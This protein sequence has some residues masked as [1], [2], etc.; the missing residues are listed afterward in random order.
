MSVMPA[1]SFADVQEAI[2]KET[3]TVLPDGRTTICQLTLVNG[4]TVFGESSCVCIENFNAELGNKYSRER[5]VDKVWPLLGYD[6]QNKVTA[7]KRAGQP[8]GEILTLGSPVTY[9]GTKVIHAVAMTRQAYNDL[10]G[11]KLPEGECGDDNGYL[12][13]YTDGG[14]PNVKGFAGYVSW[15]PQG[16]FEK[17]YV[18]GIRQKPE[19]YLDRLQVEFSELTAKVEK[20][21]LFISTTAFSK[22]SPVAQNDL[23]QQH[24]AMSRYAN[25]LSRRIVAA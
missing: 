15:S 7:I 18:T 4:Y 10:R 16:V 22:L 20:L 3:Y 17:A 6:L 23:E 13:E 19:T 1:V 9:M 5:A 24:S 12:V 25:I 2:V 21:K 8:Q 14:T 11:W